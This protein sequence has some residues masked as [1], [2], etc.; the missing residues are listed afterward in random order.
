VFNGFETQFM[1]RAEGRPCSEDEPPASRWSNNSRSAAD[2]QLDVRGG[3]EPELHDLLRSD[4][5]PIPYQ[6]QVKSAGTYELPVKFVV[7]GTFQSYPGRR[8]PEQETRRRSGSRS[9]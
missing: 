4:A 3:V 9:L 8:T 7:S 2:D 5:V 6:T 1:A